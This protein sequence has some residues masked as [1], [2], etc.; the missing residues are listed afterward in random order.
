[1]GL[2]LAIIRRD[3]TVLATGDSRNIYEAK[4]AG[5]GN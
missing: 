4:S 2:A 1:M 5:L 3:L